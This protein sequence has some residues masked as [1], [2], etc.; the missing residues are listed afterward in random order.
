MLGASSAA[1]ADCP[2]FANSNTDVATDCI[3][4]F[5]ALPSAPPNGSEPGELR[6]FDGDPGCD[7]DRTSNGECVFDLDV[8]LAQTSGRCWY[9]AVNAAFFFS[10]EDDLTEA[11]TVLRQFEHLENPGCTNGL[12]LGVPLSGDDA[13][14]RASKCV[15]LAANS[16]IGGD[17]VISDSDWMIF[18]CVPSCS[19]DCDANGEV[20]V[21]EIVTGISIALGTREAS[22]CPTLDGDGG[23]QVTVDEIMLAVTRALDGC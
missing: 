1:D 19:G 21:D 10:R 22:V 11:T 18:T 20:T 15:N 6:C 16:I 17:V 12:E 13:D 5:V 14:A 2:P 23:G 9:S 3:A 4:E 8:C 7:L